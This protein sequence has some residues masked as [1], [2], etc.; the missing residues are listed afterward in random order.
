MV[1]EVQPLR[2]RG[3]SVQADVADEVAVSDLFDQADAI[4]QSPLQRLGQPAD[5]AEMAGSGHWING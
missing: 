1:K 4:A 3:L 5:I 2:G